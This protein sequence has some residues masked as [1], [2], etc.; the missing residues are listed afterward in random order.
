MKTGKE[1]SRRWKDLLEKGKCQDAVFYTALLL[2]A[3]FL[4]WKCRYGFGNMDEAFYL[5]VPLRLLQGDALLVHEWHPSQMAGV[6]S[7]PVVWVLRMLCGGTDGI[8]LAMRYATVA[9]LCALSLYVYHRLKRYSRIGAA[10][11]AIS[12]ALYIPYG[13]TALSYNSMGIMLMV[14]SGTAMLGDAGHRHSL[15]LAG[16]SYAAACLC[17]PY[18]AAVYVLYLA[19]VLLSAL[20]VQGIRC[21]GRG[22]SAVARLGWFTAGIAAAAVLFA[23]FVFS[24]ASLMD[25]LQ[26]LPHILEDPEHQPVSMTSRI[27]GFFR[28]FLTA[29][30]TSAWIYT[31][32]AILMLICCLDKKRVSRKA[33]YFGIAWGCTVVLM[34]SHALQLRYLNM[35]MWSINVLGLMAALLSEKRSIRQ[36]FAYLWVPGML[37]AFCINM[38]SNQRFYAIASASSVAC[39]GSMVMCAIFLQELA[40]EQRSEKQRVL[41]WGMLVVVLGIQLITQAQLRLTSVFWES[42]MADQ[43]VLLEE[44]PEAGL[45]VAGQKAETYEASLEEIG[46]LREE[47]FNRMLFLSTDTWD[48]LMGDFEICSY[49]AWLSGVNETTLQRLQAYYQLHEEKMPDAVYAKLADMGIALQFSEMFDYQVER[50]TDQSIVLKK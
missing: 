20:Y 27:A 33:L 50:T 44:G 32:T 41:A 42:G 2:T 22:D 25:V 17:C 45:L 4:L 21:R 31:L 47:G 38:S 11:G 10:C 48:Y 26:A 39:L 5:T 30:Q 16:F 46:Q 28:A 1:L 15:V 35:L 18:L 19:A 6:L 8:I 43:T 7:L 3:L 14:F 40:R 29:T 9:L 13:I 49:S 36:L 37:Y 23:A 12:L 34:V 24:R